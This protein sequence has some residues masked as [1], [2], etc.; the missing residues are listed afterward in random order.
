[1]RSRQNGGAMP[2]SKTLSPMID[3]LSLWGKLSGEEKAAI[4][5]LPYVSRTLALGD[6]IVREDE[7]PTHCGVLLSGFAIRH[8]IA[9]NGGRQIFSLH[10][11]GDVADL[12]N[13]VLRRADHN[14]QTITAARLAFIPRAAIREIVV[15]YPNI[16]ETMW[17]ETLVDASIFREWT[18][19]VGRRDA[20]V[21]TAH[22]L[23]EFG[24]RMQVAGLGSKAEFALPMTQ[25]QL[26]DALALTPVH[27]NRML[28]G[29]ASEGLIE[30]NVREIRILDYP[31]LARVG[32]FDT[33]YLH[34]DG[35]RGGDGGA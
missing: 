1:M 3:K 21:R 15:R 34:L 27:V 5:A 17:Y 31:R 4:L 25:E 28:M 33:R 13:V 2:N 22:L 19:N 18:L 26:G 9:G 6:F 24:V 32:D 8:K 11:K 29:L 12:H 16:G 30:R 20:R 14:V 35:G 10:M 23:C 7:S